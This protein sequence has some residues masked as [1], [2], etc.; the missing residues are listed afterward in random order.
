VGDFSGKSDIRAKRARIHRKSTTFFLIAGT[1]NLIWETK[2]M[3]SD[4]IRGL[5]ETK[6]LDA[7][8]SKTG[9]DGLKG[10]ESPTFWSF[11]T[12][13]IRSRTI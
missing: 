12:K 2:N 9:F 13:K 6:N 3:K 10:R 1:K 7:S 11:A 8:T 5:R 4:R